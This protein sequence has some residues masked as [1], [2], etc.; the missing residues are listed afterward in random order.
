MNPDTPAATALR[1]VC[2]TDADFLYRLYASTRAAE[3]TLVD[4][5]EAQQQEFLRMQFEAQSR[6][7]AEHYPHASFDII[8][9][10]GE[11][12]GRL[13]LDRQAHEFRIIDIALLAEFRGRG[14]GN[15]QMQAIMAQAAE[16]GCC[17]TIHVE[18]NN[19]ALAL[20]QRLGF[21]LVED[22]G[23]YWFMRWSPAPQ[24]NTAS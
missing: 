2:D 17:V 9:M 18:H 22:K 13:Y 20:Y 1:P 23:V 3:M 16:H 12:I 19:P 21:E 8:E 10:D 5:S 24:E 7:Y 11:A 6:H 4:W 15:N 14:L